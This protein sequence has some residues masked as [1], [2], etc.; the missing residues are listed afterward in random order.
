VYVY[1]NIMDSTGKRPKGHAIIIASDPVP[2][3]DGGFAFRI[4]DSTGL[5]TLII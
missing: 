2:L 5:Y 1:P 4:Y 3:G